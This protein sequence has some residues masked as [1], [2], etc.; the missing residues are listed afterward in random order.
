MQGCAIETIVPLNV[1]PD[2]ALVP[3][4]PVESMY[5]FAESSPT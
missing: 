2:E 4:G 1:V 5:S 3:A